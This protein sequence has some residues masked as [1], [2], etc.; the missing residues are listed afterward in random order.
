MSPTKKRRA[1]AAGSGSL[2][3]AMPGKVLDVLVTAGQEV[4]AGAALLLLEAM[5]MELRITAPG[6]GVVKQVHVQAGD[7]VE[8]GQ[9][10]VELA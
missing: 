4:A 2:T 1:D 6:A 10:L 8:Q 5:K 9:R 3:A 7:V